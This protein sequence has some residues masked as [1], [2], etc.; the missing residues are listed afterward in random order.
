MQKP[1][2]YC[3]LALLAW[4]LMIVDRRFFKKEE[5]VAKK[6]MKDKFFRICTLIILLSSLVLIL[7]TQQRR[8]ELKA[9][10][11]EQQIMEQ[12]MK[13][14]EEKLQKHQ[15]MFDALILEWKKKAIPSWEFQAESTEDK[16][17]A[18]YRGRDDGMGFVAEG[19]PWA[20]LDLDTK[21]IRVKKEQIKFD[22]IT[23][24]DEELII[25]LKTSAE[26]E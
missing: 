8:K 13:E 3:S 21:S 25:E 26:E 20:Y 24:T 19:E 14:W 17:V 7:L 4:V 12:E 22:G 1:L 10:A 2:V 18:L 6:V 23:M 16:L 15:E 11:Q 9:A 5:H